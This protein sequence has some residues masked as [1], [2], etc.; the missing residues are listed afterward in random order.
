TGLELAD[1]RWYQAFASWKTA[2]VLQ[3]LHDRYLRGETSD[4]RMASRGDRVTE[5]AARAAR[6]LQGA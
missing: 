1:I 2:I 6:L 4:E 5:F 3:Q